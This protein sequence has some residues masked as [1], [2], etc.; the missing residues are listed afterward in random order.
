MEG[1]R[2]GVKEGESDEEERKRGK[3]GGRQERKREEIERRGEG[4]ARFD[5]CI[6]VV[7]VTF[8]SLLAPCVTCLFAGVYNSAFSVT[9]SSTCSQEAMILRG[10]RTLAPRNLSSPLRNTLYKRERKM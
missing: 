2:E 5:T 10:S 1:W 4:G 3:G 7:N 6:A 8:P 9:S